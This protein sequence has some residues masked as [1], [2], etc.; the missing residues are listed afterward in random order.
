M[1]ELYWH[2]HCDFNFNFWTIG[3]FN[4]IR[5]GASTGAIALQGVLDDYIEIS[6]IIVI[7]T[8]TE[9]RLGLSLEI[10]SRLSE[11][12]STLQDASAGFNV[13]I[14]EHRKEVGGTSFYV[15][16]LRLI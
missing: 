16:W 7:A 6:I 13:T 8:K 4:G 10:P 9:L 1:D 3:F 15:L 2:T 11:G 14:T 12:L 5:P